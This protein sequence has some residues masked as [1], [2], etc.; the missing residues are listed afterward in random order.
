MKSSHCNAIKVFAFPGQVTQ[1]VILSGV[2]SLV[3]Y[4]NTTRALKVLLRETRERERER[5]RER[6]ER[7]LTT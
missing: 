2:I 5:E 1:T 4:R 6:G 3:R 7:S